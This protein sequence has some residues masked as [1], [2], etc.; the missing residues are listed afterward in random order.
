MKAVTSLVRL[1]SWMRGYRLASA[2]ASCVCAASNMIPAAAN[3]LISISC[4][5]Y[6]ASRTTPDRWQEETHVPRAST[7]FLFQY[8]EYRV[9]L[10]MSVQAFL[11]Q[12]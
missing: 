12:T 5:L 8:I 10:D 7:G 6:A 3:A 11:L 9:N 1:S 2:D 4:L